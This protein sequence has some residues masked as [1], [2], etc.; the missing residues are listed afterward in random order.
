MGFFS[1]IANALKKTKEK[2]GG[3]I[4]SLFSRG[5][6]GDDFY[7]DLEEI[8]ISADISVTTAEETVDQLR[9]EVKKEKLKASGHK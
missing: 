5:K 2:L 8:L 6:L 4:K 3:A 9:E 1:K 7:E